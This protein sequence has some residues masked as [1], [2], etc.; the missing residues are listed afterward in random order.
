MLQVLRKIR[1]VDNVEVEYADIVEAARQSNLIKHPYGTLLSHRESHTNGYI[2]SS[3]I[4]I[5]ADS[6]FS[7]M[8]SLLSGNLSTDQPS[9]QVPDSFFTCPETVFCLQ[10]IYARGSTGPSSSSPSFS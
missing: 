1:G 6:D 10:P 9:K 4:H 3:N 7:C 5:I 2:L 8:A